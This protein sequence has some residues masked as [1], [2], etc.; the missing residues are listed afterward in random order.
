M[1]VSSEG[2]ETNTSKSS[3][4]SVSIK[5]SSTHADLLKI[6]AT[7]AD[8]EVRHPTVLIHDGIKT[9]DHIIGRISAMATI[10]KPKTH[11]KELHSRRLKVIK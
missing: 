2:T 9:M 5:D 1:G 7:C 8:A 10:V 3:S 6:D 4:D 11:I